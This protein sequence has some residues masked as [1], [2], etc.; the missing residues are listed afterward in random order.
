MSSIK[1][2]V[3]V[4]MMDVF[5]E[6]AFDGEDDFCSGGGGKVVGTR[7]LWGRKGVNLSLMSGIV[8]SVMHIPI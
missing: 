1:N 8:R 6:E 5:D 4:D 7:T 2:V 3:I